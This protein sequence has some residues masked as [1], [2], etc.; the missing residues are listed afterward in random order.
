MD[1]ARRLPLQSQMRHTGAGISSASSSRVAQVS[2]ESSKKV[3]PVGFIL[4]A[5][6]WCC[7]YSQN[8]CCDFHYAGHCSG[9]HVVIRLVKRYPQYKIVVL[10]KLDYCGSL[11]HLE[12]VASSPNYSFVRGS[13]TSADL[14]MYVM[15]KERIDTVMHFAAQTHVDN[16]F[17]NSIAFT[18]TNILGTH[19]LLEAAKEV[20]VRLFVHVSTDEVYGDGLAGVASHEGSA[21]EP[22][23]PYSA[24]KA[25]AEHLVKA[26]HRSF[27][28][29]VIITRGNNV[30]GPHQY[31]EK[32]IPKFVC[33]AVAG[34]PLTLHGDGSNCRNYLYVEDVAAAFDV[35]LH[36]GVSGAVYNMGGANELSNLQVARAVLRLLG[37]VT[38]SDADDSSASASGAL[39]ESACGS[40]SAGSAASEPGT[41]ARPD[42]AAASPLSVSTAAGTLL[43]A[44]SP[45]EKALIMCVRDRPF[46][47][48]R[49]P[50][51]CS[52]LEELGWREAVSWE[53][54]LRRT[55]SW[56][57]THMDHW[58]TPDIEQALVAHPRRGLTAAE[59][60]T[61]VPAPRERTDSEVGASLG[62]AAAGA[63]GAPAPPSAS[64]ATSAAVAAS[65]EDP[66]A[67]FARTRAAAAAS[68]AAAVA[69]A[70]ALEHEAGAG[71]AHAAAAAVAAS[72]PVPPPLAAA[73]GAGAPIGAAA[74]AAAA[75]WGRRFVAEYAASPTHGRGTGPQQPQVVYVG[76]TRSAAA[77]ASAGGPAHTAPSLPAPGR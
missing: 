28:L 24:T 4:D 64:A 9:S 56:Y 48:L 65:E 57:L 75:A 71:A 6:H 49:Y 38:D 73:A 29:P 41:D 1:A 50:L 19:V 8:G 16:S 17:G 5:P 37:I 55:V 22:T 2:C 35:I 12:S 45:R 34:L 60:L 53:E 51:D 30:Y 27:G 25:G 70:H 20:G 10:D 15:R 58:A 61:G 43:P 31:P 67:L 62:A 44:L 11:K 72:L 77:A 66:I 42:G 26:Y 33:Q 52:R 39:A 54:G 18:E 59:V 47:D 23:N 13:I 21:L 40:A 69:A 36:R 68:S 7:K 74:A 32:I 3:L 76:V 63:S 46:N 14:V